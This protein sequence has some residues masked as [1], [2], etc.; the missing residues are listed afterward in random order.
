MKKDWKSLRLEELDISMTLKGKHPPG[1]GGGETPP[2]PGTP[3]PELPE[4]DS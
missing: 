3:D 1:G 2:D 4:L